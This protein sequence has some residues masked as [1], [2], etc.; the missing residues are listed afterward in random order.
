MSVA[1]YD[2][3]FY[4]WTRRQAEALRTRRLGA[5]D[6]EYDRLAEEI[7]D[8][9]AA[10]KNAVTSAVRLILEHL[11]KLH[12]TR[13][14]EPVGHWKAE[15]ENFRAELETHVT[16]TIRR[17]VEADLEKLHARAARIAALK[18]ES[19]ELDAAVDA[20]LRWSWEQ[21][22]GMGDDPLERV[23]PVEGS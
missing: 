20:D 13:R 12:A 8:L 18:F 2:R 6:V 4:L 3:D 16:P 23:F 10:Q 11:Y 14:P 5:N 22:A 7:E 19:D 21:I 17:L 1:L 9:G 15:V